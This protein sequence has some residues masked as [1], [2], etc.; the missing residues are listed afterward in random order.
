MAERFKMNDL[1]RRCLHKANQASFEYDFVAYGYWMMRAGA[2]EKMQ[3]EY[4][5]RIN[6]K[7]EAK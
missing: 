7:K 6:Q 3:E 5:Y 4:E 2:Y 1:V